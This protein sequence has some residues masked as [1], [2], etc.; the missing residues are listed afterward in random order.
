MRYWNTLYRQVNGIPMVTNC[1]PLVADLLLYCYERDFMFS[2][3]SQSQADVISAFNDISRYLDDIFNI[4]NP[5][6]DNMVPIIYPK[7][8]KLN[9]ANTSDAS[10][11]FLD[12]D[13]SMDNSVISSK[14]YN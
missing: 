14:I 2:L 3:D 11:A 13:L 10:A 12:L 9:K 4:H 7:E 5:L 8:L 6:F 1:A